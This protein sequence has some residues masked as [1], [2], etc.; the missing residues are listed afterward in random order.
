MAV[1]T[2]LTVIT[3]PLGSGKTTLLRGILSAPPGRLAV[4]MNEFGEIAIDSRILEGK[5]IRL[6]EL[7]GGCVCCSL[8]GEFEAAV[9]E[10]LETVEPDAI[11]L[12]TTGLAEPGA[13]VLDVQ[14]HVPRV[15][16]DGVVTLID[17][18]ALE[19]FPQLGHTT[20][21]QVEEADLLVLNKT[22]LV[23]PRTLE[24]MERRL[25]DLNPNAAL[26]RTVRGRVH[27]DVLFGLGR[28][29]PASAPDHRHELDMEAF[30]YAP[31]TLDRACF[32]A[33]AKTLAGQHAVFRAKGFVRFQEQ[34]CLF[35]FVA[36]RW[37]LEPCS[38]EPP[39]LVFIGSHALAQKDQLLADLRRCETE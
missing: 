39:R 22:D 13:L 29:R 3:G 12:E 20:R 30:D 8:A 14:E 4:L 1:R 6:A 16:L 31:R 24:P 32:E 15:R 26:V 21:L 9:H 37:E 10:V 38:I 23:A 28:T 35:N 36:G 25:R 2:P 27:P 11:L 17:A 5:H 18:D 33:W 19:R 34:T 7:A